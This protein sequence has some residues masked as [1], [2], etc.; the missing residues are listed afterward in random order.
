[1]SRLTL[2]VAASALMILSVSPAAAA[3]QEVVS[4]EDHMTCAAIFFAQSQVSTDAEEIDAFETATGLMLNRA[5]PLGVQQ[6]VDLEQIIERSAAEADQI[7]ART[8][9]APAD[10]RDQIIWNWGIG[11][12]RCITAALGE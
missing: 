12:D 4:L 8:N 3:P 1:M 7:L 5:E 6:G 11:M 2:A 10:Q 9:A